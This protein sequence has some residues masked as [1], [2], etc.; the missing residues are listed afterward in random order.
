MPN[1]GVGVGVGGGGGLGVK[2]KCTESGAGESP[3]MMPFGKRSENG[4]KVFDTGD[5]PG[6]AA[7]GKQNMSKSAKLAIKRNIVILL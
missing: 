4:T 5:G 1:A 7:P 3:N 2:S 6:W